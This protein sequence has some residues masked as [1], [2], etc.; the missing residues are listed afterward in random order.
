MP[1]SR[2]QHRHNHFDADSDPDEDDIEDHLRIGPN[3]FF[4]RPRREPG[5]RQDQVR[6]GDVVLQRFADMLMNDLGAARQRRPGQETLFPH[7]PD[8]LFPPSPGRNTTTQTFTGFG[9][10]PSTRIQRTT[11]TSGPMGGSFTITTT[12]GGLNDGPPDIPGF[13]AYVTH[14]SYAP[15]FAILQKTDV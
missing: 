15:R 14:G 3:P 2:F 5:S 1:S 13:P 7:G 8:T 12:T 6:N 11:F 10:S 4:P 9:G